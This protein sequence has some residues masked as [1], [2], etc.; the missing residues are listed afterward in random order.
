MPEFTRLLGEWWYLLRFSVSFETFAVFWNVTTFWLVIC[1]QLK[2]ELSASM[3][4]AEIPKGL[5]EQVIRL[6]LNVEALV[7]SADSFTV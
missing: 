7:S 3:F 1:Y 6:T 5:P 2:T 4:R